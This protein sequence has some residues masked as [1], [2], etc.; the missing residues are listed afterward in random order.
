M[1][2]GNKSNY[3][4]LL[5]TQKKNIKNTCNQT[6]CLEKTHQKYFVAHLSERK[7]A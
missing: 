4:S 6:L 7:R 1:R 5:F 2:V 3:L